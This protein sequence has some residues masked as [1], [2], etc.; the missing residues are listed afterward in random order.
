MKLWSALF[1]VDHEGAVLEGLERPPVRDS[2]RHLVG[3]DE[4][5]P[6]RELEEQIAPATRE[7]PWV[8]H[9]A[10][11]ARRG[12]GPARSRQPPMYDIST[13]SSR[14]VAAVLSSE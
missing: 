8:A 9:P 12:G 10:I 14:A 3:E 4:S 5:E 6:E 13:L 1:G 2:A 11:L 7:E